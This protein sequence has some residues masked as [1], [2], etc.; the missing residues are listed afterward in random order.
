MM[1]SQ[2]VEFSKMLQKQLIFCSPFG[3]GNSGGFRSPLPL[4]VG[5][6][7]ACGCTQTFF[8]AYSRVRL[9]ECRNCSAMVRPSMG[10]V[11]PASHSSQ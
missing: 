7:D 10:M 11:S 6:T 8:A 3:F 5:G 1:I 9:S 4:Y 2:M